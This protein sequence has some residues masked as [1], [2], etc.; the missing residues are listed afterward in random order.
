MQYLLCLALLCLPRTGLDV[1][2]KPALAPAATAAHGPDVI[3]KGFM[4]SERG[5]G[6]LPILVP[7]GEELTFEVLIDVGFLGDVNVGSVVLSSGVEPYLAGLPVA[8]QPIGD[9]AA[10][11][12]NRELGWVKSVATGGY[13][14]YR[15][16]HEIETRLLPQAYPSLFLRETQRGSEN[17]RKEIKIGMRDGKLI[18]DYRSDRHCPGCDN[19]EHFV[20]SKW[21]WGKPEHC[22]KC[23]LAEHRIWRPVVTHDVPAGTLD[24]L[25]AVYLARSLVREGR[26]REEFPLIDEDNIWSV[27]IKRGSRR[28]VTTPAGRFDCVQVALGTKLLVGEKGAEKQPQQFQGLFG[29]Q[30]RIRIWM[31]VNSGVPVLIEGDLPV[32]I[33]FVD[34]LNVSVQL[35]SYRGTTATFVPVK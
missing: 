20:E 19:K 33:P 16:Q 22:K 28:K 31:E 17:R 24:M 34:K 21:L 18:A 3:D 30:G 15:V 12:K 29:L 14:G 13:L 23:K 25:S 11:A 6:M 1:E 4:R 35:K 9:H 10:T 26:E 32:P 7:N 5:E 27:E 8:G 2:D